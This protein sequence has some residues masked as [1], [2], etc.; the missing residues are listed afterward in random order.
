MFQA[1]PGTFDVLPPASARYERLIALFA[2]LAEGAGYGLILGPL[3]ED[4]G[5]FERVGT[6]T[7]IV[8]KEM[9]RF[10]DRG[11]RDLVLRP[12]STASVVRAYLQHR[13]TLP[14][15]AWYL[16]P[17]FRY[18]RP[19][20]GRYRQHHSLGLEALGSD[21]ADLDVEVIHLAW[22]VYE[23]L[24][25]RDIRMRLTSLG[26]AACRPQYRAELQAFLE[27]RR[28]ELC[29]E[30][31]DRIAD[32]PLRL[33]D[34]KRE[35]CRA[36]TA[37]VPRMLDRLCEPCETHF[38]RVRAGLDSEAV[39]VPYSIDPSLVRGLDYYTRTT[40]EFEAGALDSAQNAAGGGGR[41]DGLVEEMGGSPTPGIG[42]GLGIERMLIVCDAEKVFPT[43][44]HT[45]DVFVIDTT[46]GD[47]GRD[48]TAELRRAGVRADRAF[49]NRSFKSQLKAALRS[50]ARFAVAAEPDGITL[51]TLLQNE[52][53]DAE[54]L[55]RADVVDRVKARLDKAHH[56]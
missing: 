27:A 21:D 36:V 46:G 55:D 44:E 43:P 53:A 30:H 24:G 39:A 12:E 11:G 45:L 48:L 52:K 56:S 23:A 25:V 29:D 47:A 22:R 37:E 35:A 5:V 50:G 31:R 34:C 16:M 1:P 33:L 10:T 54:P 4:V 8:R 3:F 40:F 2:S 14:F 9:Y 51:R 7:D 17:H 26:D 13:P 38:N 41:Y 20:R 28:G 49:D 15:K 18:E 42:F 6:S 19:Q 32:N